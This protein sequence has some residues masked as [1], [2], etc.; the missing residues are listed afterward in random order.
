MYPAPPVTNIFI[1][2]N[3]PFDASLVYLGSNTKGTIG[4]WEVSYAFTFF[5]TAAEAALPC[6]AA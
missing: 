3:C 4:V 6:T 1:K 5:E 2:K